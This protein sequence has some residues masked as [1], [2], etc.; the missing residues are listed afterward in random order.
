[1]FLIIR[2]FDHIASVVSKTS[3]SPKVIFN[4]SKLLLK[5]L[6]TFL[7]ENLIINTTLFK[8]F[9][10]RFTLD[11]VD[12][13][14]QMFFLELSPELIRVAKSKYLSNERNIKCQRVKLKLN[15]YISI[16]LLKKCFSW[17]GS[18]RNRL[19]FNYLFHFMWYNNYSCSFI[20]IIRN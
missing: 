2:F 16:I 19:W 1:M 5:R 9:H 10:R 12:R 15:I 8:C 7:K 18:K 6:L 13:K 4:S 20:F 17:L 14:L 3:S 11:A